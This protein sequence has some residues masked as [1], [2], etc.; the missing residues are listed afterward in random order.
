MLVKL[1]IYINKLIIEYSQC[2]ALQKGDKLL[3]LNL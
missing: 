3:L 1:N 2:E